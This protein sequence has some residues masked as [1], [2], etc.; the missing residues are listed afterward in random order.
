MIPFYIEAACS[1]F[2]RALIKMLSSPILKLSLR[3]FDVEVN[4]IPAFCVV[5]AYDPRPLGMSRTIFVWK[6]RFDPTSA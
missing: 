1:C 3:F 6:E 5:N 4:T 2:A